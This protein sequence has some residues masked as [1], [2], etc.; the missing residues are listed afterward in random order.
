MNKYNLINFG[1]NVMTIM[2]KKGGSTLKL[3]WLK[4]TN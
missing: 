4:P 1:V 3:F 2:W